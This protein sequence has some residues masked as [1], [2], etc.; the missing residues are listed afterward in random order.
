MALIKINVDN[1]SY[2]LKQCFRKDDKGYDTISRVDTFS[3]MLDT[4]FT[5]YIKELLKTEFKG[6]YC[7]YSGG[8]DLILIS[9]FSDATKITR[10][11]NLEF[12]NYVGKNNNFTL[13]VSEKTFH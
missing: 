5:Q 13:S 9:P 4:F 8:D 12:N 3:R 1:L 6:T 2:I 11:I 10:C 7:I